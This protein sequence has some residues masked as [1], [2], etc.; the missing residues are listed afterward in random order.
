MSRTWRPI[1]RLHG[2]IHRGA[3][4]AKPSRRV[5]IPKPDGQQRPLGV[6]SLEDKIVQQAVLWVLQ[7]IYEQ[8]FS[9]SAMASG[10]DAASMMHSMHRRAIHGKRVNW[11]WM[12]ISKGSSTRSTTNGS[13]VLEHRIGDRRMSLD[14]QMASGRGQ[15]S[16]PVV[17]NEGR[18]PAGASYRRCWQ[19]CSCT[20]FD[21]WVQWWRK[22]RTGRRRHH[23]LCG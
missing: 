13:S 11:Y 23:P 18:N 21:L 12:P 5:W 22:P 4:R 19:M 3:Y 16:R 1:S 8:D 17:G 7:S 9:D 14:P 20:R 6:A 15:R 2:R 10:R